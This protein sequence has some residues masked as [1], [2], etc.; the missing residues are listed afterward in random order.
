MNKVLFEQVGNFFLLDYSPSHSE[1]VLRTIIKDDSTRNYDFF[2]KGVSFVSIATKFK[3]VSIVEANKEN[4][5]ENNRVI[6]SGD[7]PQ[8]KLFAIRD[9]EMNNYYILAY[10]FCVFENRL[11]ILDSP[12]GNKLWSEINKQIFMS[13]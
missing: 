5:F 4:Y 1:L 9:I 7:D 6:I 11:N 10:W 12:L 13:V 8:K 2:F 3:N